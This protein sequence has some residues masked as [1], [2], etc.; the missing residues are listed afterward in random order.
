MAVITKLIGWYRR[1]SVAI[2]AVITAGTGL[3]TA[4]STHLTPEQVASLTALVGAVT[5]L[6][7]RSQ[8]TPTAPAP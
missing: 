1:E 5:A 6:L 2:G 4:F 8:V 7:A 3:L